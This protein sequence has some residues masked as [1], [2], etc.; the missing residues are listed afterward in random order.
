M[1]KTALKLLIMTMLV[2]LALPSV[3]LTAAGQ[4]PVSSA[5][6][7][8]L[9]DLDDAT[10]AKFD[11]M[12]Q[13]GVFDGVAEGK[14][15]LQEE[16]NRAQI[17]KV[18]SL[19]IGLKVDSTVKQ[20]TF[21]DVKADDPANGWAIPYI[22]AVKNAGITNGTGVGTFDPGGKV[23]KEQLA[24]F[25]IRALGQEELAKKEPGVADSTVSDWAR[26]Y[27]A[28]A[29]QQ[30]LLASAGDRKFH[31]PSPATRETLVLSSFEALQKY[32]PPQS[33]LYAIKSVEAIGARKLAVHLTKAGKGTPLS[34]QVSKKGEGLSA[35]AVEWTD[36]M[37]AVLTMNRKFGDELFQVSLSGDVPLATAGKSK[38]VQTVKEK[39]ETIRFLNPSEFLPFGEDTVVA[40]EALNQY[41]EVT[42]LTAEDFRVKMTA[43]TA[44]PVD[45]RQAFLLK[46]KNAM[47]KEK[48]EITVSILS[49]DGAQA[50]KTFRIGQ[51][52]IASAVQ[53]LG[54][55]EASGQPAGQLTGGSTG[56]LRFGLL[57][58][59]GNPYLN[60]DR[61]GETVSV[62][63]TN[64][65]L[66]ASRSYSPL[67]E[68]RYSVL[69]SA[70]GVNK[71]TKV[72]VTVSTPAGGKDSLEV[73]IVPDPKAPEDG[74]IWLPLPTP[75]NSPTPTPTPTST[76]TPTPTPT[77]TSTPTPTPTPTT[78]PT[79]PPVQ[80]PI[81]NDVSIGPLAVGEAVYA[82]S[83][84]DG[85]IFLV[86]TGVWKDGITYDELNAAVLA[87]HAVRWNTLG[88]LPS[89]RSTEGFLPGT[90]KVVAAD[91]Q[92]SLSVWLFHVLLKEWVPH[93][94]YLRENTDTHQIEVKTDTDG[95]VYMVPLTV[96]RSNLDPDGFPDAAKLDELIAAGSSGIG[97]IDVTANTMGY[98][99]KSPV[100]N[101]GSYQIFIV[102]AQGN[103]SATT[104]IMLS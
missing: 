66:Q 72:T 8:D 7:P 70:A 21:T 34:F 6:F 48:T 78:E 58:Q 15:G 53:V 41:K 80:G 36:P 43:G 82:T 50:V 13:A 46:L 23:T 69:L 40:F 29:L 1:K 90:F 44:E 57:D 54:L 20:S 96:Y 39:I 102:D 86:E 33:D 31:G 83:S 59:Y 38:F 77:P 18:L 16:M 2:P 71:L 63:T 26:G 62:S 10:K 61:L 25:L 92:G 51:R 85:E 84:V 45:G 95:K 97:R 104:D 94:T 32:V 35:S 49:Q 27:V 55:Y 5:D 14:F 30:K 12:I 64:S 52:P 91:S 75:I 93:V 88:G 103:L 19:I 74:G 11:A 99:Q 22:E 3:T 47:P 98:M 17:A 42:D 79:S 37:T 101:A 76:S 65:V 100:M 81:L 73:A 67:G 68:G 60:T 9:K 24:A 89:Y 28:L 56:S 87:E 4:K